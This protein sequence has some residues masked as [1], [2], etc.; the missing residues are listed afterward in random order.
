M[1]SLT[2]I[3]A[4]ALAGCASTYQ[5]TVMP[6]DSGKLYSGVAQ[7]AGNGEGRISLTIDGKEYAGTWVETPPS[8]TTGFVTGF[9]F[10]RGGMGSFITM[11]NPQGGESKALLAA[12][13]GS[14]L[15]CD[16]KSGQG[17]GGGVCKDDKGRE[18]D[19]QVR[20]T[21]SK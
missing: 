20:R 19:V 8:S 10:R 18:Y 3:A 1:R 12:A 11:D 21:E 17:R 13:D 5:L 14:G 9:G 2:F 7:D 4:L 6:R 15:R 16:F